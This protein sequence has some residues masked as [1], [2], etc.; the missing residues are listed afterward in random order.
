MEKCLYA[1]SLFP[2]GG[3]GVCGTRA[4][5][6]PLLTKTLCFTS[7]CVTR[8]TRAWPVAFYPEYSSH[9]AQL[10][11][12]TTSCPPSIYYTGGGTET[13]VVLRDTLYIMYIIIICKIWFIWLYIECIIIH[14]ILY[15]LI[16]IL[17]FVKKMI[18]KLFREKCYFRLI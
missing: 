9:Q 5:N 18:Q 7:R 16:S 10:K 12:T 1:S 3:R 15:N 17:H 4:P 2:D 11:R 14:I 6:R 8:D 13:P